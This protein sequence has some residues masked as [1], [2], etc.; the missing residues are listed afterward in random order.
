MLEV[1]KDG[2]QEVLDFANERYGHKMVK[3]KFR[4]YEM[5]DAVEIPY[6]VAQCVQRGANPAFSLG[7][8]IWFYEDRRFFPALWE[9]RTDGVYWLERQWQDDLRR[10]KPASVDRIAAMMAINMIRVAHDT[11]LM[12]AYIE[13]LPGDDCRKLVSDLSDTSGLILYQNKS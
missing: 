10:L 5:P 4:L 1:A 9:G 6:R 3:E 11:D 2:R 12:D 13:G 8:R 7:S